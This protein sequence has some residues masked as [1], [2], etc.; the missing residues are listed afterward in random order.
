M[1]VIGLY[2]DINRFLEFLRYQTRL[3]NKSENLFKRIPFL[4]SKLE[5]KSN[6]IEI[7]IEEFEDIR[8]RDVYGLL[9]QEFTEIIEKK[10]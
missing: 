4:E 6:K 3:N 1:V 10:G 7:M 8:R 2:N 5:E 9:V